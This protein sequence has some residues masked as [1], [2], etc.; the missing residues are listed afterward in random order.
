MLKSISTK[1]GLAALA[2]GALTFAGATAMTVNQAEAKHG[3]KKG[4][5][6]SKHGH[7]HWGHGHGRGHWGWGGPRFVYGAPLYVGGYGCYR[8]WR[9]IYIPGEGY[10][11][12]RTR[13]CD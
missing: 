6:W 3:G 8:V 1:S 2:I 9:T 10:V 11:R 5:G 12:A 13:V 4:G 7:G